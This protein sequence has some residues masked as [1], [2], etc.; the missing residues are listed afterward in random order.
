MVTYVDRVFTIPNFIS[1]YRLAAAPVATGFAFAGYI[2]TFA[3]LICV[4]LLTDV[5]DGFLARLL[6]QRTRFGARLDSIADD[7]TFAAAIVGI[8]LF[9]YETIGSSIWWLYAFIFMFVMSTIVPI[10]K[11]GRTPSFHLYSFKING[12]ILA[13]FFFVLFTFGFYKPFFYFAMIYGIISCLEVII[14]SIVLSKPE[15]D[16]Q[17]LYWILKRRSDN[18]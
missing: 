2:N 11:F 8:F 10:A 4:S 17:G 6:N 14:V 18:R 12:Y 5:L 3:T 15:S 1:A 16:V 13:A 9:Q 7:A